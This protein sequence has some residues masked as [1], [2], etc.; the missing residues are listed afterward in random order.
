MKPRETIPERSASLLRERVLSSRF[1]QPL[2]LVGR[3]S[4]ASPLPT[5]TLA[6]GGETGTD[7]SSVHVQC[8]ANPLGPSMLKYNLREAKCSLHHS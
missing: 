1:T 7:L 8:D 6:I 4:M 2:V 3:S 5:R